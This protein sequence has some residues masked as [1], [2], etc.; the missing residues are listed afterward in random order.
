MTTR[1]W[2]RALTII[3][4]VALAI[5]VLYL[6]EMRH[7]PFFAV[8]IGDAKQYDD[9]AQQIASGQ[10]VGTEI[11]YQTP[12]YP[13]LL[14]IVY[15]LTG[16]HVLVIRAM[17][18]CF[19]AMSCVLLAIAGR[20][21]FNARVGLIAAALLA[22][23]PPAIFFDGLIQKSSLDLLLMTMVLAIAGE[24]LDRPS[25]RWMAGLGVTFG[26]L[27][28]NRENTRVLY[29]ILALWIWLAFSRNT[30]KQRATWI[31]IF[32]AAIAIVLLPVALRNERV[33]HE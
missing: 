13:Y 2:P 21:F 10:W 26:A 32:T 6:A 25:W 17:Q 20:R 5:R 12:L 29:P 23:Y 1:Q 8:L 14:A 31:A 28:L 11:F 22:I 16:H 19:G 30:P 3:G 27:M 9:W 7:T 15:K 33:G 18:A 4:I 24:C